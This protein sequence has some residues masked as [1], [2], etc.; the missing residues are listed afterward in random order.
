M[1]RSALLR[2]AVA[3]AIAFPTLT[4]SA[5]SLWFGDKDGLHRIDTATNHVAAN[6]PFET[7][8]A[9]AVNAADGSLWALSQD[10]LAH[11]SEQGVLQSAVSLR[12]LEPGGGAPRLLALN[13]NDGSVWVQFENRILHVDAAG[14]PRSAIAAAARDFAVA[15]DGS[16]WIL[17]DSSLQHRDAAG[18]LLGSTTLPSTRLKYLALDDAGGALWVAGE[19][20]LVQ[21]RL[22]APEQTLLSL[23]APE[24]ASVLR[25]F[26]TLAYVRNCT[27]GRRWI[28]RSVAETPA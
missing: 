13:P 10:R 15:Q 4:L 8:A 20:D 19:K 9:I 2:L 24:T 22:S 6:V 18:A 16:L 28:G 5:A 14:V 1:Y 23:V 7:A 3:L 21:L 11:L 26:V 27:V 25:M 12:D 17:T